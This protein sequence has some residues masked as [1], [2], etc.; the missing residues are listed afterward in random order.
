MHSKQPETGSSLFIRFK[1]DF[2]FDK[3]IL[4][5]HNNTNSK[6]SG[7][8][9]QQQF[10]VKYQIWIQTKVCIIWIIQIYEHNFKI[11]LIEHLHPT[12]YQWSPWLSEINFPPIIYCVRPKLVYT[13]FLPLCYHQFCTNIQYGFFYRW[14]H[15]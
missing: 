6:T 13:R 9:R 1:S 5:N 10:V 8:Q 11:N 3:T 15:V 12:A 14:K 2:I 4:K 7:Y